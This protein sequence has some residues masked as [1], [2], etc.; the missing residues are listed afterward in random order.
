MSDAESRSNGRGGDW[1]RLE[2]AARRLMR[3]LEQARGRAHAAERR[4]HELE[5]AL[6]QVSG[7]KVDPTDLQRRLDRATAE[8]RELRERL[9]EARQRVQRVVARLD[10]VEEAR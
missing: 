8:N 1:D 10:F 2:R 9:E 4:A 7:G 5:T 3:E 6:K